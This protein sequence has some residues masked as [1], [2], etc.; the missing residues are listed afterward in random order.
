[1]NLAFILK[2]FGVEITA[3]QIAAAQD[4]AQRLPAIVA[5]VLKRFDEM[6]A[7]NIDTH[8]MVRQMHAQQ[9]GLGGSLEDVWTQ[10]VAAAFAMGNF[11]VSSLMSTEEL[12]D[13]GTNENRIGSDGDADG[14]DGRNAVVRQH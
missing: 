9:C 12:T 6:E 5:D 3:E 11:D 13:A 14:N 10:Q 4:T 7:R 2:S 1:M 8:R